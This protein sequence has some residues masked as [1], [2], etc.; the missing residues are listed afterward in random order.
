MG[1][2]APGTSPAPITGLGQEPLARVQYWA[3][4]ADNH[5]QNL[6]IAMRR[7]LSSVAERID[8]LDG[9]IDAVLAWENLFSGRPETSMRVCGAIAWFLEPQSY[10]RRAQLYSELTKLYTNRSKLVHGSTATIDDAAAARDRSVQI[11]IECIKRLYDNPSLL[12]AKDSST[13][14]Q[15]LL[16]GSNIN[17]E[18]VD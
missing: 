8:P 17:E 6:D 18:E 16:M 5:P 9:F 10:D 2:G 3:Q 12:N 11:S 7:T 14:G 13:R 15:M 1:L 4:K